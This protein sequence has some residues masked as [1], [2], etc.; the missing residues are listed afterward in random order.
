MHISRNHPKDPFPIKWPI[1]KSLPLS[2]SPQKIRVLPAVGKDPESQR[3]ERIKVRG[4]QDSILQL[5]ILNFVVLCSVCLLWLSYSY[6]KLCA[7]VYTWL[8]T[9]RL[10]VE[11]VK[12]GRNSKVS[13]NHK[14]KCNSASPPPP[15]THAPLTERGREASSSYSS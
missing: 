6:L 10:C 11:G 15:S 12:E 4:E 5:N 14:L 3:S 2:P 1:Y 13:N 8:E 7:C 9:R